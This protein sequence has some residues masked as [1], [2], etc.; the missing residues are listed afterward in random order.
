[1]SEAVSIGRARGLS[2]STLKIIAMVTMFIDHIGA[3]VVERGFL[4][5]Q[6][7]AEGVALNFAVIKSQ[8]PT[9]S[10]QLQQYLMMDAVLRLI[11]RLAFPKIG[12]AH[13]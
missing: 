8:F 1:M 6:L 7:Q 9:M 11:G 12:R 5:P 2:G 10:A 4:Y 3:A 13:V